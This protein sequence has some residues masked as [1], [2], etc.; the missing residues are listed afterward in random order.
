[1]SIPLNRQQI[2]P[3]AR[4]VNSRLYRTCVSYNSGVM[5]RKTTAMLRLVA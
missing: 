4:T 5:Q 2:D 1:M 3:L